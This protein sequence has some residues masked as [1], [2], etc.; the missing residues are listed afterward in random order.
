MA[1]AES[2]QFALRVMR[3]VA[4]LNPNKARWQPLLTVV[5]TMRM[6]HDWQPADILSLVGGYALE[7]LALG[8]RFTSMTAVHIPGEQFSRRRPDAHAVVLA[9][10][11]WAPGWGEI[12]TDLTAKTAQAAFQAEWEAYRDTW[13]ATVSCIFSKYRPRRLSGSGRCG[14][15]PEAIG[16]NRRR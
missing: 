3:V 8:R 2:G 10:V 11:H 1:A 7:K 4:R 12:H 6:D 14:R 9:R 15:E 5:L 16:S 13:P